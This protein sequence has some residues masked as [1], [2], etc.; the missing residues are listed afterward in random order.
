MLSLGLLSLLLSLALLRLAL[1]EEGF[2]NIRLDLEVVKLCKV[3][4]LVLQHS[5]ESEGTT[6]LRIIRT[7]MHQRTSFP[8]SQYSPH[9]HPRS[10]SWRVDSVWLYRHAFRPQFARLGKSRHDHYPSR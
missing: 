4:L 5:L 10:S 3:Q 6:S 1:P 7:G 9:Y 2:E 8:L